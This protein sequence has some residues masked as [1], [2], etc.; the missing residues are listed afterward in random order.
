M[1]WRDVRRRLV[2]GYVAV[3]VCTLLAGTPVISELSAQTGPPPAYPELRVDA[4]VGRGTALH[5]GGGVVLP[6]GPYVRLGVIGAAGATWRDG[7]TKA[8]GRLDAVARYL[9]DPFREVPLGLSLGG[10]LTLPYASGEKTLRPYLTA[11]VDLE[12][13]RRGGLTPALQIGVG[14]G[15]RIGLALRRSIAAW[16]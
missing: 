9:L 6:M 16:R 15:A 13:R 7:S 11:V 12:A 1:R 2:A 5:A 10:G 14:G 8:S 3:A 4:I